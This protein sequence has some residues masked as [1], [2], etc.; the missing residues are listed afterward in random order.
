MSET[1]IK[2]LN[3]VGSSYRDYTRLPRPVQEEMGFALYRA[4]VGGR[5][6]MAKTLKGFGGGGI[7]ELVGSFDGDAF[8][9][10]YTVKFA[11]EV[12]VLHAFQKKSKKGIVTPR[13]DIELVKRRLKEAE[14]DYH[15][16]YGAT[17]ERPKRR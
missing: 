15:E 2:P 6:P 3:W 10:V 17:G 1:P 7:L 11:E 16:R 5:H 9:T 13:S 14:K 12:Y 4:Q 8:R